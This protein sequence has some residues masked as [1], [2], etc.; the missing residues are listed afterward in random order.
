[1]REHP[2]FERE[3]A[4]LSCEVPISFATAALGGTVEVPTL[5]G[6][7]VLKIPAETQS[8]RVFRLREKG[9]HRCAAAPP[10]TCSAASWSRRR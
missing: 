7:V 4:N 9:V 6:G 3:G 2:I 8:G 1:M 10:A 5:D